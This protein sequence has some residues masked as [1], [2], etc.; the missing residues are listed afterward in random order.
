[1]R[2]VVVALA[3]AF[4]ALAVPAA[5]LSG[6][7]GKSAT[8]D[9]FSCKR[10]SQPAGRTMSVQA[11]MRHRNGTQRLAMRFELL[12]TVPGRTPYNEHGG[13]LDQWRHPTNPPTLGQR[14]NDVWR[15]TQKVS[16]LATNGTYQFRVFF[17]WTGKGGS[18]LYQTSVLSR[19]C[20]EG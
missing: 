19:H 10:S 17:K 15:V 4:G 3:I 13:T 9:Q 7:A 18:T 6:G 1:M 8:L 2:R 14:P 16:N 12:W 5:A 20:R 11:V